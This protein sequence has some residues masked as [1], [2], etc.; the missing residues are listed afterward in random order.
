MLSSSRSALNEVASVIGPA[1]ATSS[2]TT[3]TIRRSTVRRMSSLIGR[4][5][6]HMLAV[7]RGRDGHAVDDKPIAGHPCDLEPA[8]IG[9]PGPAQL[10]D[11][12]LGGP[13]PDHPLV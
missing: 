3:S 5:R 1:T 8:R 12:L 10:G 11:R 7:A 9:H 13:Q 2:P 4:P 6:D